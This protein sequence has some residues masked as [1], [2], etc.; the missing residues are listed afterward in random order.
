MVTRVGAPGHEGWLYLVVNA[1]MKGAD[2]AH[3]QA[4]LP[5]GVTLN[6]KDGLALMAPQG[7]S[8]AAV[9][10]KL[11]PE[12]A[13]VPFMMSADVQIDG[14]WCH[15][16]RSGYTGEDGF[17]I[18]LPC[19]GCGQAL[20]HPARRSGGEGHRPRR[21]RF[22]AARSRACA[23]TAMTSTPRPRPSRAA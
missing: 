10:A 9:L 15:V 14:I 8:A 1:S 5:K 2:Y 4:R 7:P 16:S 18:S 13:D 11:A 17:E 6:P 19:G 22:A 23:S 12:T 20:E 21:A 3:I